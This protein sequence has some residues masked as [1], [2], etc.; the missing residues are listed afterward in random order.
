MQLVIYSGIQ[1]SHD[2]CNEIR[3]I[4]EYIRRYITT[5]GVDLWIVND[6]L[7][8]D[9]SRLPPQF[10]ELLSSMQAIIVNEVVWEDEKFI[11]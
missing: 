1:Y 11:S 3:L 5:T 2:S 8:R 7:Q 10:K 4:L 6:F 9:N